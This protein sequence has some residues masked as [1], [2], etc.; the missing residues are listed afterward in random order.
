MTES[1]ERTRT[2][3]PVNQAHI[4]VREIVEDLGV[5]VYDA[6]VVRECPRMVA[7][8]EMNSCQAPNSIHIGSVD[9]AGC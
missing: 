9:C 5:L 4:K 3:S 8:S 6:A 7:S 1:G 2:G